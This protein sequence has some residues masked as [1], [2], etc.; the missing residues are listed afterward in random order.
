MA[1]GRN[2]VDYTG[3]GYQAITVE[4]DASTI[5]FDATQPGGSAQVGKAV[6]WVDDDIVKLTEDGEFVLGKLLKVEPDGKANVQHRGMVTLPAG[7]GP[8][9]VTQGKA[10]VGALGAASAK[11]FIRE[12]ATATAAELG[13]Q[14]GHIVNNAVTTAVVVDLG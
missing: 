13:R 2:K 8:A 4:I 1:A 10:I 5:L 14:N 9:A 7:T 11:G 6:T 3:I 12:V